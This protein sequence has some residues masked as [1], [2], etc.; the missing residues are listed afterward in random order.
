VRA[1][2]TLDVHQAVPQRRAD[3]LAEHPALEVDGPEQVGV[4]DE[5]LRP[6]EQQVA[7][8]IEGEVESL[9]HARLRLGV[10]VHERV[11]AGEQ[12]DA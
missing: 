12:V 7:P 9:E 2:L 11:A 8:G 6:A 1:G 5:H 10:E 4:R 3:H